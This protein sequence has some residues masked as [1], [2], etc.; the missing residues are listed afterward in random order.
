MTLI[1]FW[2]HVR[3]RDVQRALKLPCIPLA[4]RG[5]FACKPR[6]V[7]A[8]LAAAFKASDQNRLKFPSLANL[9]VRAMTSTPS[10]PCWRHA[11]TRLCTEQRSKGATASSVAIPDD[12][13]L[14]W[15]TLSRRPQSARSGQRHLAAQ[16]RQQIEQQ[17]AQLPGGN[18]GVGVKAVLDS[19][20]ALSSRI[21]FLPGLRPV[22][23]SI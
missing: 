2:A 14:A 15:H 4:A 21:S 22:L 9:L 20:A 16:R 19:S 3:A 1:L 5:S 17:F 8:A 11:L 7:R 12:V 10:A 18:G 13:D 23:A 6:P